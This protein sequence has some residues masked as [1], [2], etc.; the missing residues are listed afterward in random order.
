MTVPSLQ[1]VFTNESAL[2]FRE[3]NHL[4]KINNLIQIDTDKILY[5]FP[6]KRMKRKNDQN[7][8]PCGSLE[9]VT[10]LVQWFKIRENKSENENFPFYSK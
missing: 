10:V 8:S 2:T 9:R 3:N 1:I 6:R 7:L 5:S 4:R